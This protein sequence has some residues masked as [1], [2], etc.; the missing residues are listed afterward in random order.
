MKSSR[1]VIGVSFLTASGVSKDYLQKNPDVKSTG[2]AGG[3]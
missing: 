1:E 3:F 2:R